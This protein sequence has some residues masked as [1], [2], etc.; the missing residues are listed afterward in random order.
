MWIVELGYE[1]FVL[2]RFLCF[3]FVILL[4]SWGHFLGNVVSQ[5]VT[6]CFK[7]REFYEI[8]KIRFLSR[9]ITRDHKSVDYN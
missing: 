3:I 9:P 5:H 8:L 2:T 6:T 7:I 1:Y 4:A